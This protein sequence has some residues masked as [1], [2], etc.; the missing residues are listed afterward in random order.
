MRFLSFATVVL[1]VAALCAACKPSRNAAGAPAEDPVQVLEAGVTRIAPGREESRPQTSGRVVLIWGS[2]AKP[3]AF[4]LQPPSGPTLGPARHRRGRGA[5]AVAVNTDQIQKG[6]TLTLYFG[7]DAQEGG[8]STYDTP[9]LPAD[10]KPSTLYF[11]TTR[12]AWRAEPLPQLREKP[13]LAP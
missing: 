2:T 5:S 10:L 12:N 13:V 7:A 3:T 1:V 11:Y 8:Y 9:L 6:D 4:Y